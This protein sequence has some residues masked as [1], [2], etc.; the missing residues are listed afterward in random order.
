MQATEPAAG[1]LY[2]VGTPIGNLNDLSPRARHVLGGVD[3]IAC[4]D[5]RHSG[6]LLHN[7]G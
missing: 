4:E 5:T 3:R 2:L 7:L 6:L 1:V